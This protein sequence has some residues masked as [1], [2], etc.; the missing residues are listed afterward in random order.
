MRPWNCGEKN[1]DAGYKTREAISDMGAQIVHLWDGRARY[2]YRV[3][4]GQTGRGGFRDIGAAYQTLGAALLVADNG[5]KFRR[6]PRNALSKSL[7][8]RACARTPVLGPVSH[9]H[10]Q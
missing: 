1:K 7:C 6:Q 5:L 8:G 4:I 9:A 3:Q 2:F 10:R